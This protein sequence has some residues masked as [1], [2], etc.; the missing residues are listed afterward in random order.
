MAAGK[1]K[2]LPAPIDRPLSRA[3]LR[4]FSG[5]SNEFPPNVS[6]P[7]TMRVMENMLV[8]REGSLRVRPGLKL[9]SFSDTFI[10]G[11]PASVSLRSSHETFYLNDGSRA[12][13]FA[14][15]GIGGVV[16]KALTDLDSANP[17]V[18]ELS[19][20]GFSGSAAFTLG[21][22]YVKF[23]QIDNK[24]VALSNNGEDPI[25]LNTGAT[26]SISQP[27][28]VEQPTLSTYA[29]VI[30][31]PTTANINRARLNKMVNYC[32]NPKFSNTVTIGTGNAS[33]DVNQ[34]NSTEASLDASQ[35][36]S[37]TRSLKLK[38]NG[39]NQISAAIKVVK[40]WAIDDLRVNARIRTSTSMNVK[41]SVQWLDSSLN[42]VSTGPIVSTTVGPGSWTLV[43]SVAGV[44]TFAANEE[45]SAWVNVYTSG[46]ISANETIHIDAVVATEDISGVVGLLAPFDGSTAS[47]G[48]VYNYSWAGLADASVSYCSTKEDVDLR[49]STFFTDAEQTE[50]NRRG[51]NAHS[52]ISHATPSDN[53]YTVGVFF[54]LSNK[55]G[56]SEPSETTFIK[57]QRPVSQWEFETSEGNK[58]SG[59]ATNRA[60]LMADQL[61][62]NIP[63]DLTDAYMLL[64]FEKCNV[65]MYEWGPQDAAP[66]EAKRVAVFN[67]RPPTFVGSIPM[68][69]K[70]WAFINAAD[71]MNADK[72][73]PIPNVNTKENF[74]IPFTGGQG[75][76]SG[77]RM[78]LT[79]NPN[80]A[81]RIAWTSN[82]TEEYLNFTSSDGGGYKTLS[83]GNLNIPACV[84]LWQNPES[85]D[86]LIVLCRGEGGNSVSY[87]MAPAEV[88]QQSDSTV[89]MSF[90]ETTATPGT[91]SPYGCEVL[92]NSLYHP[93]ESEVTK[94]TASNY[95]INHK[96]MTENISRSWKKLLNKQNIVSSVL[97]N[98]IYYLVHNPEGEIIEPG[99][100][101]NEIWVLDMGIENGA[102]SRWLVQGV[103]L[104]KIEVQGQIYMSLSKP[105]GMYYFD[106]E[107]AT[108][109]YTAPFSL[110]QS[111][112][113]PWKFEMNTQGA[114]RAHDAWAHLRQVTTS[115][116]NFKGEAE[117][118]VKGMDQYGK[119]IIVKKRTTRYDL[120][121]PPV[122][123]ISDFED[124][125]QVRR[126]MKEWI[127]F[128]NSVMDG[129]D[130]VESYGQFSAVQYRYTPVSVNVGYEYGSIE[131][132]EYTRNMNAHG[133]YLE[134]LF[135]DGVPSNMTDRRLP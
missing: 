59:R 113:I 28:R 2:S 30:V 46:A 54:T 70:H 125:L 56:E 52:L 90:E 106:P 74:S 20:L 129:P 21:T 87:Y 85:K 62:V 66:I 24:I 115:F 38:E 102:W 47:M 44:T 124:H 96:G 68:A 36:Y 108:D 111:R 71:V 119:E 84:K 61:L 132:F 3:Y 117:W 83:S 98:R 103:S 34:T 50:G 131:T 26:K 67:V 39:G 73:I 93:I 6:D 57:I 65:Y 13:V 82:H 77:D 18:K 127:F 41:V 45:Y 33:V 95:N 134:T 79:H 51:F 42:V 17:K 4:E 121:S 32:L 100:M 7:T 78:I 76:V 80:Q 116:G 97:D 120:A 118:G 60:D 9:L 64:G 91:T 107:K 112:F 11:S 72:S 16:F 19:A 63:K 40:N 104:R 81:A 22:T 1:D 92:N 135:H 88:G 27:H 10:A 133:T 126:D 37:G 110:V 89:I 25:I 86:T 43:G 105:D 122:L 55:W 8:N 29:P 48:S 75:L 58:P 130:V 101:G 53:E 14:T 94:S 15:V 109:D 114:N 35:Y 128:A 123:E 12:Y 23:L 5:W 49:Q 69:N 31:Q 99:C